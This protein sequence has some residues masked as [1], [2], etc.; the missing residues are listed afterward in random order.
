MNHAQHEAT[1]ASRLTFQATTGCGIG[2]VLGLGNFASI[3]LGI[4]RWL[5]ARR[6]MC[7]VVHGAHS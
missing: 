7:A 2:E 1:G 5:I 3:V 4:N 6:P